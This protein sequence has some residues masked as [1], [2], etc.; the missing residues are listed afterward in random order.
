MAGKRK[1][2]GS[3]TE[4]MEYFKEQGAKGGKKRAATMTKAQRSESARK[5]AAARWKA[6]KARA[7]RK[8]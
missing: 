7:K 3:M 8:S 2:F 5:A 6:A 4:M 1:E